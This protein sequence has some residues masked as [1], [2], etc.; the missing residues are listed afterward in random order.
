MSRAA[1]VDWLARNGYG[2]DYAHDVDPPCTVRELAE[3]Y[4]RLTHD[5][6]SVETWEWCIQENTGAF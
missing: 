2:I 3:A 6:E 4:V 1:W 5:G